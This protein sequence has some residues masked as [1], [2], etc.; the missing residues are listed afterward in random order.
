MK[1]AFMAFIAAFF[2]ASQ[3]GF[4]QSPTTSEKVATTKSEKSRKLHKGSKSSKPAEK[5]AHRKTERRKHRRK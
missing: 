5:P 4:A 1:R 3:I 2:L